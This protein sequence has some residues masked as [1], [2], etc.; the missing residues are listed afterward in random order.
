[1]TTY[2]GDSVMV[3]KGISANSRTGLVIVL[4]I[5]NSRQYIDEILHPHVTP[6]NAGMPSSEMIMQNP[7]VLAIV[8][9]FFRAEQSYANLVAPKSLY[10]ACVVHLW[11]MHG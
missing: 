6:R 5:P 10:F 4:D 7:T 1:M 11:G 2:N 9:D 8:V 3:W